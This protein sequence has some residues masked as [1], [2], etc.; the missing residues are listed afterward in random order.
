M[1]RTAGQ[2]I[3]QIDKGGIQVK[4][5]LSLLG[6]FLGLGLIIILFSILEPGKF[7]TAYNFMRVA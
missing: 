1:N 6:P 4:K 7:S 2:L 5:M 3:S